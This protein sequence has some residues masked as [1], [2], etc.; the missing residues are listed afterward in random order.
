MTRRSPLGPWLKL[1]VTAL[2]TKAHYTD[3]QFR[4]LVETWMHALR[5]PVRGQFA[6]RSALDR[7]VGSDNVDFLLRQGDLELLANSSVIVHKW[8]EY[9]AGVLSTERGSRSNV[10]GSDPVENSSATAPE[11]FANSS[12]T[13]ARDAGLSSTLYEEETTV[14]GNE[15]IDARD[16]NDPLDVF[17][18]VTNDFP[19]APKLKRWIADVA[20]RG[21]H[22]RDFRVVFTKAWVETGYKVPDALK[23]T[24]DRLSSMSHRAEQAEA[25]KPKPVDP[26]L[27]AQRA[28]YEARYG[29][30][31]VEVAP[32]P[33]PAAAA[34]GRAAFEALRGSFGPRGGLPVG[35]GA[36]LQSRKN[37]SI[38]SVDP[39]LTVDEGSK[40]SAGY[41]VGGGD[42]IAGVQSSERAPSPPATGAASVPTPNR[43]RPSRAVH[44]EASTDEASG[45]RQ[46]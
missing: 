28:A 21:P 22:P 9:Q 4:A 41:I 26:L 12:L 25:K 1:Y 38:G 32:E 44:A 16:P 27:E 45:R 37:G 31:E 20:S 7:K 18:E 40:A 2:D 5:Q 43:A 3:S 33:D 15:R 11:Q 29:P 34:A 8:T 10:N 23:L 42:A 39:A 30:E 46:G 14:D 35:V 6:N 17:Y 13:R 36:V 19:N 24:G